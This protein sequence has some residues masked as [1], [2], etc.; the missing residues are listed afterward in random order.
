MPRTGSRLSEQDC[1][2][3]VVVVIDPTARAKTAAQRKFRILELLFLSPKIFSENRFAL[4]RIMRWKTT[5]RFFKAALFPPEALVPSGR[6]PIIP[7]I[8]SVWPRDRA[9]RQRS[10]IR[11][12]CGRLI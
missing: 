1:A 9:R 3:A 8:G 12:R 11:R 6:R 7:S 2:I 10:P 5:A 4:F